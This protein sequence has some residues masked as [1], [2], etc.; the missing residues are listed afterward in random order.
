M[1]EIKK[2]AIPGK[3]EP[4]KR[5]EPRSIII[6]SAPKIG[7]TAITAQLPD[8]LLVEHETGGADAVS[9][10]CIEVF[11]PN[12]ILPLLAQVA[13]DDTIDTLVIDTITKWDKLN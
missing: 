1:A 6:Y 8:S 3:P 9:A 4:P 5:T 7:K 11:N 2:F 12:D 13:T 10:R